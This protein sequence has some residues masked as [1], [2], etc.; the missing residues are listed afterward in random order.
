MGVQI[1]GSNSWREY[2]GKV[3]MP[4]SNGTTHLAVV[5]DQHGQL[6]D[7]YVKL[8]EPTQPNLLCEAVGWLLARELKIPTPE[9]AAVVMVP[10]GHLSQY[11]SLPA[12]I[13][14]IPEHPAWCCEVVRGKAIRQIS[15][16]LIH[17]AIRKCL[18]SEDTRAIAALDIWADNQDRN[19]GNVIQMGSRYVAIDHEALLHSLFPPRYERRS[20]VDSAR[21]ILSQEAFKEFCVAT[22]AASKSHFGAFPSA[23]LKISQFVQTAYGAGHPIEQAVI[24]FLKNRSNLTFVSRELGVLI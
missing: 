2:R 14:A 12:D 8:M 6:H 7:C 10:T 19:F 23:S 13:L 5:A 20:V 24:A 21:D 1:L 4:G 15:R 17:L 22:A 18:A 16:W 11:L 9:F 3:S